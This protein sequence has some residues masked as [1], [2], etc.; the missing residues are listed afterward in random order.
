MDVR[1]ATD[2]AFMTQLTVALN[3]Q[4]P[5][6]TMNGHDDAGTGRPASLSARPYS[7][8]ESSRVR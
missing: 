4:S 6:G 7:G 2:D 8:T 1:P 3:V 5:R